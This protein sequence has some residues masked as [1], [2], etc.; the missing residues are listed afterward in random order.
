MAKYINPIETLPIHYREKLKNR[1]MTL[2]E[3]DI[4]FNSIR[5]KY[6]KRKKLTLIM[7]ILI[8]VMFLLRTIPTL[9]KI[10]QNQ[11]VQ[12]FLTILYAVMAIA[13]STVS[14]ILLYNI[15]VIVPKQ[16][17]NYLRMGY[18]ELIS[19]YGYRAIKS[20]LVKTKI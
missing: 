17:D 18:P 9:I 1:Q 16:F 2:E 7:P 20:P 10:L 19:R 6:H 4:L 8:I 14:F 11:K 13:M 15:S 3:I 5:H 12:M